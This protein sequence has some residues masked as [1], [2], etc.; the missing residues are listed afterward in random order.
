MV[1]E[2]R[3]G[4]SALYGQEQCA[5]MSF[6]T[7]VTDQ[8]QVY[9]DRCRRFAAEI[10]E[11]H[12][13]QYDEQKRFPT[14]IHAEAYNWGLINVAIPADLGGGGLSL[15]AAIRGG[16]ALATVCAPTTFSLGIST[17]ALQPI[18]LA[19]T[20]EQKQVFVQ[21]LLLHRGYASFCLTEEE[22]G[23]NLMALQTRAT[24]EGGRWIVRGTKCMVGMGTE[25]RLFIVLAEAVV[26]GL[27]RGLTFFA[28]PRG[29]GVEV[30]ESNDKLGFRAVPTP[31]VRFDDVEI[32][33]E[34]VIGEIGGAESTLFRALEFMRVGSSAI[35][36][37]IVSG[38]IEDAVSWLEQRN[39][40]GGRLIDKSHVRIVLG[41]IC[42]RRLAARTVLSHAAELLDRNRP[43]R[44][45][46]ATAKLLASELAV[47]ATEAVVQMFGWRGID[48]RFSI[49]KRFRDAR[50]TTIFEGTSELLRSSLFSELLR[51]RRMDGARSGI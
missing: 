39:V 26:N 23:S 14:S 35:M 44:Q 17:G 2:H 46:S 13:R 1:G 4:N 7:E 30:G 48:S 18:L 27:S 12:Y 15:R 50:Q 51:D 10:I 45:E 8:E 25:S 29:P 36:L 31:S 3:A 33:D 42:A 19:G 41:D 49:Q 22:S 9:F 34:H 32:T 28:V 16:E 37:G 11:P 24:K 6:S 5:M 20:P 21:D 38:A 43:C 40:H 47:D